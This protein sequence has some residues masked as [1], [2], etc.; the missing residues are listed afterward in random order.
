VTLPAEIAFGGILMPGIFV[1][2]LIALVL[3]LGSRRLL[4]RI[5]FYRL[6][7]HPTLFTLALFVLILGGIVAL[8]T[9]TSR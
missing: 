4:S 6:V 9:G 7:W 8:T 3:T 1:A 2:A 5:R